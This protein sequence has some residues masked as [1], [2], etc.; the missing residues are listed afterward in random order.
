MTQGI[1][2]V[3]VVMIYAVLQ[4][5][6]AADHLASHEVRLLAYFPSSKRMCPNSPGSAK[7]S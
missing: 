3:I 4:V 7:A 6:P 5:L 1:L 2:F